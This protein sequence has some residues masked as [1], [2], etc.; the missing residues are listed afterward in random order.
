MAV[1]NS[2]TF[3]LR[4]YL[5]NIVHDNFFSHKYYETLIEHARLRMY[6][7]ILVAGCLVGVVRKSVLYF[8]ST[9]ISTMC[10]LCSYDDS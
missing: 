6:I 1:I 5:L 9:G 4:N 8:A 3:F 7:L 10:T 2:G